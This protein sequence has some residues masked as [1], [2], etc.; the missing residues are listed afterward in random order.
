VSRP[1]IFVLPTPQNEPVKDYAPGSPE[2]ASLKARLKTM[3]AEK[4][5]MPLIIGGKEIC[6]GDMA[7]SVMPH[8]HK[9]VL[10][11]FHQATEQHVV[12]EI[13]AARRTVAIASVQNLYN[14]QTRNAESVVDYCERAN[15][16]FIPWFPIASGKLADPGGPV[17]EIAGRT[18]DRSAD[19][20]NA[21]HVLVKGYTQLTGAG[22][23]GEAVERQAGEYDL[24]LIFEFTGVSA[25]ASEGLERHELLEAANPLI[26]TENG[27][28]GWG[29]A[30]YQHPDGED[31][32]GASSPK[33]PRTYNH[34]IDTRARWHK[35]HES[36]ST[37]GDLTHGVPESEYRGLLC[38]LSIIAKHTFCNGTSRSLIAE[39]ALRSEFFQMLS[40]SWMAA[41]RKLRAS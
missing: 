11:T 30:A 14:L 2:R 12:Q 8:D 31:P 37:S 32:I 36:R 40:V 13:E 9:H 1:G 19:G 6:S 7:A 20:A 26:R 28:S 3:A 39:K 35:C 22:Q 25:L 18:S 23:I 29:M 41:C 34:A 16:G 27:D 21:I 17:A 15:I 38:R 33:D 5:D 24:A 10:G 4:V